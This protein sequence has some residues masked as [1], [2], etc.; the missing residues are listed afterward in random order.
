MLYR[1]EESENRSRIDRV[2]SN[3]YIPSMT[4][5]FNEYDEEPRASAASSSKLGPRSRGSKA[6]SLGSNEMLLRDLPGE[7]RK[8]LEA[9][10][11]HMD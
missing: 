4:P 7:V 9:Q 5:L 11:H 1:R 2:S 6:F 8:S 10:L 3:S